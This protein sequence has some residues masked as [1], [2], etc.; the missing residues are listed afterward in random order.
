[1]RKGV[2]LNDTN[3]HVYYLKSILMFCLKEYEESLADLEKAIDKSEDNV[4]G[5]FY[6]RGLL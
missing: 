5:H 3:A 4:A 1:M 6:V 2:E